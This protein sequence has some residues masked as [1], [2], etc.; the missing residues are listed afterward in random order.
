M[1]D[2]VSVP[3][4]L[5][6][7]KTK[8]DIDRM[9]ESIKPLMEELRPKCGEEKQLETVLAIARQLFPIGAHIKVKNTGYTAKVVRY[10]TNLGGFYPGVRY[11]IIVKIT[12]SND[13]KFRKGAVGSTFEYTTDQLELVNESICIWPDCTW[14]REEE[15][16]E[17]GMSKS[18]DFKVVEIPL[19]S[20]DEIEEQVCS[21]L[22]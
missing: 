19:M 4:F 20:D 5:E 12:H 9:W 22:L 11:P 10:N 21:G 7:L 8:E 15:L 2:K 6:E 13:F 14:C 3:K 16:E 1:D 17:Y 18:D